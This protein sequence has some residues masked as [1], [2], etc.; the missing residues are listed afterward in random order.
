VHIWFLALWASIISGV[1][2]SR[3]AW[4]YIVGGIAGLGAAL[5]FLL[6]IFVHDIQGMPLL[7]LWSILFVFAM[8]AHLGEGIGRIRSDWMVL[9][10]ANVAAF[11]LSV[12]AIVAL[13]ST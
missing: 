7:T 1:I 3:S 12:A 2:I 13:V 5:P 9:G 10:V 4:W 11:M 8:F 6:Y